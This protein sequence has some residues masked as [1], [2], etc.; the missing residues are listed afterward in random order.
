MKL[1]VLVVLGRWNYPVKFSISPYLSN[2]CQKKHQM[3]DSRETNATKL[4]WK[5]AYIDS[6]PEKGSGSFYKA[7][8]PNPIFPTNV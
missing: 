7:E 1:L 5:N 2:G 3:N 6:V 8:L 4:F